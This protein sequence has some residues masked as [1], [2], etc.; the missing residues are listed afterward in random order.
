MTG[1]SSIEKRGPYSSIASVTLMVA[2]EL[3]REIKKR[4]GVRPAVASLL[5]LIPNSIFELARKRIGP[6]YWD[7]TQ[8]AEN[9]SAAGFT[10]LATR[11]TFLNGASVL[12]WAR[13]DVEES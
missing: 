7:E 12:V 8:F 4:D 13:R 6:H 11:R 10:V 1:R 3:K 9:L 5:W 2:R